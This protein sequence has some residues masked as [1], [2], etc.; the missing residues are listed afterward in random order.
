[1]SDPVL[2]GSCHCG[3]VRFAITGRPGP[4]GHCHCSRCRKVSGAAFHTS[5]QVRARYFEWAAGRE[6][7]ASYVP[8]PPFTIVRDFC[9]VCG[10]YLG[11]LVSGLDP[12]VVSAAILDGDLGRRPSGHEWVS[13]AVPWYG[14]HDDLPCFP[15][16]FPGADV[17]T[18]GDVDAHTTPARPM[19]PATVPASPV[20]GSCLCG[21]V[22][23]AYE[24]E[25]SFVACCHCV[26]CRRTQG[27]DFATNGSIPRE[28]LRLTSGHDALR[29]Y[30]SSPGKER[31]FCSRCS[32][33][34]YNRMPQADTHFRLRMGA[35]D[36]DPGV[37]PRAH[38]FTSQ[39]VPWQTYDPE[40]KG[41]PKSLT[42]SRDS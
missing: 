35:L 29:A 23:Y 34:I 8:E 5:V 1:M 14:F 36:D 37:R 33:P 13:A 42:A 31:W 30:A 28:R 22:R 15:E 2:R 40:L 17:W 19:L 39:A 6:L 26:D 25:L 20:R 10:C 9:P 32:T 24:G 4:M 16:G 41:Y 7:V 12:L 18:T 27:A 3:G 21:E 38:V 11:E